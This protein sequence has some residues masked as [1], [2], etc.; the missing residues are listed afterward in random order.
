[1]F[2][3]HRVSFESFVV[4]VVWS[5]GAL[6]H[7]G[8]L[9]VLCVPLSYI[10]V[11]SVV[12]WYPCRCCLRLGAS[13][14]V[15][16][17]CVYSCALGGCGLSCISRLSSIIHVP[18]CLWSSCVRTFLLFSAH[19]VAVNFSALA[20]SISVSLRRFVSVCVCVVHA[21]AD[22]VLPSFSCAC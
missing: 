7:V 2:P 13:A 10:F 6:E 14:C 1:M 21:R 22:V 3:L 17:V 5:T 4:V 12:V 9:V 16:C 11:V 20:P 19:T 8:A 18:L 15:R